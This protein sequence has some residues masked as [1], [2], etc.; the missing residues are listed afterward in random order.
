MAKQGFRPKRT[1][2]FAFGHDEKWAAPRRKAIAARYW[3]RAAAADFVS[4]GPLDHE[5]SSRAS[6]RRR[7]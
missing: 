6:T 4:T 3:P 7:R 2:Y 5:A 1:V